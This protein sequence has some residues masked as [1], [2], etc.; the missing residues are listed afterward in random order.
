MNLP[1]Y[2]Q[3]DLFQGIMEN[4]QGIFTLFLCVA[5][6]PTFTDTP[7]QYVEA[8][9]GGS[10]TLSCTAFGNPKPSVSWLRE[11]D[12]VQDSSKYKVSKHIS[13][14]GILTVCPP[15]V[16]FKKKYSFLYQKQLLF[17]FRPLSQ[18]LLQPSSGQYMLIN[19]KYVICCVALNDFGRVFFL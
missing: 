16:Q 18:P 17:I 19:I 13:N 9:E 8:K 3:A 4:R 5:A 10:I 11:G 14:L 2:R 6:P 12:P 7:P 1:Y 15:D